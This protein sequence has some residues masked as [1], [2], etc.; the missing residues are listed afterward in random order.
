MKNPVEFSHSLGQEQ[1]FEL[2][3]KST[4][5]AGAPFVDIG[6]EPHSTL[7]AE[8]WSSPYFIQLVKT[9]PATNLA[10]LL[11]RLPNIMQLFSHEAD[12]SKPNTK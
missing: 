9:P 7:R 5:N 2:L 11:E 8:H 12:N 1:K 6:H 10:G 4:T 3:V